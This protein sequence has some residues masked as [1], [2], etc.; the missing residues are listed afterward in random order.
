MSDEYMP[1]IEAEEEWVEFEEEIDTR[2]VDE[3]LTVLC[4]LIGNVNSETIKEYLEITC[5][6]IANLVYEE[7]QEEEEEETEAA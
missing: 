4:N 5:D 7:E 3:V 2:E 1:E 6:D